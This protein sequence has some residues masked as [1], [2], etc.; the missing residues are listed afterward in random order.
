MIDNL[1]DVPENL[2]LFLTFSTQKRKLNKIDE[3]GKK[4]NPKRTV[5]VLPSGNRPAFGCLSVLR[6][7]K[8]WFLICIF[9]F[10][11]KNY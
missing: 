8:K 5:W 10:S 6:S 11:M 4:L 3:K 1:T 2:K 9:F 7:S